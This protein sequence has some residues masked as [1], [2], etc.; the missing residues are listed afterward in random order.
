M[1]DEIQVRFK[2][3]DQ[4]GAKRV[5]L[6]NNTRQHGRLRPE[7]VCSV[8]CVPYCRVPRELARR[9]RRVTLFS[10]VVERC[11]S[12]T[13]QGVTHMPCLLSPSVRRPNV[14]DPLSAPVEVTAGES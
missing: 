7:R 5:L 4:S 2:R 11:D 9:R 10:F 14:S 12:Q 6:Q 1:M 3:S 13:R 8:F